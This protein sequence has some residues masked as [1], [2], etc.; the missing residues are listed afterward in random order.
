MIKKFHCF[1]AKKFTPDYK[2]YLFEALRESCRTSCSHTTTDKRSKKDD[3]KSFVV[4]DLHREALTGKGRV[5]GVSMSLVRILM[6]IYLKKRIFCLKK[7]QHGRYFI[8]LGH[9]Y[10]RRDVMCRF[11]TGCKV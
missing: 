6:Q 1:Q 10:G 11:S 9:Q 5:R 3:F 7:V 4:P 8:V 2:F